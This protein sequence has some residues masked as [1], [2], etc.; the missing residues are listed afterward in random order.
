MTRPSRS[1]ATLSSGQWSALEAV[2]GR[3]ESAWRAGQCAA[4]PDLAAFLEPPST[5]AVPRRVLLTE[6]I[7]VDLEMRL[8]AGEPVRVETYLERY[9]ELLE[10]AAVAVELIRAEYLRRRQSNASVTIDEYLRRF[11]QFTELI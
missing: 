4:Q 1:S 10:E 3:F 2:I 8:K 6:L 5:E 11:P 9:P 7:N